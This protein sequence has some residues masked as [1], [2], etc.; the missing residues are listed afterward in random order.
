MLGL[1]FFFHISG[2]LA[3]VVMVFFGYRVTVVIGACLYMVGFISLSHM[4]DNVKLFK[5]LIYGPVGK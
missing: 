2:G 5:F 4:E 1:T 3:A